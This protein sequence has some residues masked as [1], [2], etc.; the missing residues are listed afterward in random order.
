MEPVLILD[1]ICKLIFLEIKKSRTYLR[2]A[3]Q[4][5]PSSQS[6]LAALLKAVNHAH[7]QS[8]TCGFCKGHKPSYPMRPSIV[9]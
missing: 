7:L 4:I 3:H 8:S 5:K 6:Q 1:D 9:A 2:E